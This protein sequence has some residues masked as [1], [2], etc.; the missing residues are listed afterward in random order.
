MGVGRG[1]DVHLLI[2]SC[3]E[4]LVAHAEPAGT[5]IHVSRHLRSQAEYHN[6]TLPISQPKNY[7]KPR[8]E[9][10]WSVHVGGALEVLDLVSPSLGHKLGPKPEPFQPHFCFHFIR[11]AVS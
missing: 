3:T 2:C 10:R 5:S 1:Y 9:L 6:L 7:D 11:S 8:R 4:L